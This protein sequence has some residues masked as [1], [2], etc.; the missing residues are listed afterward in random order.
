[1][2]SASN[3]P[4]IQSPGGRIGAH[5][6][7]PL[8]ALI[9]GFWSYVTSGV[10]VA[11]LLFIIVNFY[12]FSS[13]ISVDTFLLMFL[14]LT[15][16]TDGLFLLAHLLRR[17]LK[18]PTYSFDPRKVSAVLACYNGAD[19]IGPTIE[20]LARH[21][22]KNQ[23]IVV[24]DASTDNTAEVARSYGVQVIENKEN[25]NKAFSIS[26]GVHAVKTRYVL[27]L[28]DDVLIGDAVIPTSLLDDG[29]SAVAFNVQPIKTDTFI[30]ALQMFEY[31]ASM[32]IGKNL[33]AK[34]SAVGNV[35]GAIG[36]FRTRDLRKQ[37]FLH[38]GQFAGEDEQRTILSHIYGS[39]S[40]VTYV[41]ETVYTHVPNTLHALYRQR[42]YGW[43]LSVPELIPLYLKVLFSPKY[44][45]LLKSEKAYNLYIYLTD[46]LR[47]LF[48]WTL[49]LRPRYI[50]LT[51]SLYL[52]LNTAMWLKTGRKDQF[53]VVL[54]YPFYSLFLGVFRQIG[55]FYWFKVK[56]V[57]FKKRFHHRVYSRRMVAEAMFVAV[58]FV[59]SWSVSA[60]HFNQERNLFNKVQ[61]SRL[62]ENVQNFGYEY[63]QPA[64]QLA[65][66]QQLNMPISTGAQP[67]ASTSIAVEV[68]TGDTVRSITHKLVGITMSGDA[69]LY[70]PYVHRTAVNNAVANYLQTNGGY[71]NINSSTLLVDSA[72][73]KQVM[74][75]ALQEQY[76][77]TQ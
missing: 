66:I 69:S 7:N 14:I 75:V 15:L 36:L 46:P 37:A 77:K 6:H 9:G 24:S 25:V 39:G 57:Y 60:W 59:G 10:I 47:L 71:L 72:A 27:I 64:N 49:L 73:V 45:Y 62:E 16:I 23:I 74:A 11:I 40:G 1:M 70:T 12:I 18:N 35:S 48:L 52:L 38:S 5:K 76:A 32:H 8:R 44:H 28:D 41:D 3:K 20:Q 13:I 21:I 58:I 26:I 56:Y 19:E 63:E 61:A 29:Y 30:N 67:A 50:F 33:R 68:E 53:L 22:P 65:T 4:G 55:N 43:S 54:V 51:F 34:A 42:S 17:P 2:A 31:R